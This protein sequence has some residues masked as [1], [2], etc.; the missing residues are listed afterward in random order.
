MPRRVRGREQGWRLAPHLAIRH[1]VTTSTTRCHSWLGTENPHM[2]AWE[3]L[4]LQRWGSRDRQERR[5]CSQEPLWAG[6]GR[7]GPRRQ[8]Q[9]K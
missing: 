2:W 9:E 7:T 8:T 4:L 5:G 6:C 3:P 1:G